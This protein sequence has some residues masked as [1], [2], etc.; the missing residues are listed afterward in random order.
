MLAIKMLFIERRKTYH[1]I[2]TTAAA[3]FAGI[4]LF[5]IFNNPYINQYDFLDLGYDFLLKVAM[6][7]IISIIC[8]SLMIYSFRYYNKMN[9]RLLGCIRVLGYGYSKTYLYQMAQ[10]LM[11][12]VISYALACL[13]SL[14]AVPLAQMLIYHVMN[15]S[16]NI[17]Y[18]DLEAYSIS[19]FYV[20]SA[21]LVGLFMQVEY[22]NQTPIPQLIKGDEV[23]SF[24][25]HE[26]YRFLEWVYIFFIFLGLYTVAFEPLDQGKIVPAGFCVIGFYGFL[27]CLVPVLLEKWKARHDFDGQTSLF[28]G[29]LTLLLNQMKSMYLLYFFAIFILSVM[30]CAN[31]GTLQYYIEFQLTYLLCIVIMIFSFIARFRLR[32]VQKASYYMGLYKLG[33]TCEDIRSLVKR[34]AMSIYWLMNMMIVL[35]LIVMMGACVTRGEIGIGLMLIVFLEFFIPMFIGGMVISYEEGA[36]V[37]QWKKSLKQSH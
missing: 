13:L 27:Y 17:F 28:I 2:G 25:K 6:I 30:I 14:I 31:Q 23:I 10:M 37:E 11:M 26:R 9:S 8:L 32:R 1:L 35:F 5:Q 20:L 12:I 21:V 34:E 24:K 7:L 3:F 33:M 36:S 22:I 19:F 4:M 15:I 29:Q 16:Q 18:Y